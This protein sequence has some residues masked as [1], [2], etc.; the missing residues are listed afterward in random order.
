M[1]HLFALARVARWLD[2]RSL[3][4]LLAVRRSWRA[5]V[6]SRDRAV[7]KVLIAERCRS[8]L[9]PQGDAHLY[10]Q[11]ARA[12][13]LLE[14]V[15]RGGHSDSSGVDVRAAASSGCSL[16]MCCV[17]EVA[18]RVGDA[19]VRALLPEHGVSPA[20]FLLSCPADASDGARALCGH[21]LAPGVC[22]RC[23]R[24]G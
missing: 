23:A 9:A 12:R 11:A 3:A 4:A 13:P 6:L 5:G 2:V 8:S 14:L 18:A 19:F 15:L 22:F 24:G 20:G 1:A 10:R 17:G 7:L 16:E 21:Y